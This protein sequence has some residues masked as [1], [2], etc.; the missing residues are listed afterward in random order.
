MVCWLWEWLQLGQHMFLALHT[1]TYDHTNYILLIIARRCVGCVT[2]P[3]QKLHTTNQVYF[4]H[5]FQNKQLTLCSIHPLSGREWKAISIKA[6]RSPGDRERK[7]EMQRRKWET[8]RGGVFPFIITI[9]GSFCSV[10]VTGRLASITVP[11]SAMWS[12]DKLAKLHQS[13]ELMQHCSQ[14]SFP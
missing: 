12:H 11:L 8:E 14:V 6:M 5:L 4:S 10:V 3:S 9:S 7:Q 2:L 13:S 1:H